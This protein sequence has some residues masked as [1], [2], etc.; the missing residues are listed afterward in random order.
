M[1]ARSRF[2]ALCSRNWLM[3]TIKARS[4]AGSRGLPVLW[5]CPYATSL[6]EHSGHVRFR[7]SL[8]DYPPSTIA[9]ADKLPVNRHENARTL[10]DNCFAIG[11]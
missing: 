11:P 8:A 9:V 2:Q 3:V 7:G 1:R 4:S 6:A 5:T 10:A